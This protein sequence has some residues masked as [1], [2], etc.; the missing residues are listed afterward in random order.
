MLF[1]FF[2]EASFQ[3]QKNPAE[4][5]NSAVL[6]ADGPEMVVLMLDKDKSQ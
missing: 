4:Q 5:T 6:R 1:G 3:E 2:S